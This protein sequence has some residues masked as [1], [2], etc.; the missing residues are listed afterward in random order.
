M[1]QRKIPKRRPALNG[2]THAHY[3]NVHELQLLEM[4]QISKCLQHFPIQV[5]EPESTAIR[6]SVHKENPVHARAKKSAPLLKILLQS[7]GSKFAEKTF[8]G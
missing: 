1:K 7:K 4:L 5:I 6:K 8:A 3:L 2:E